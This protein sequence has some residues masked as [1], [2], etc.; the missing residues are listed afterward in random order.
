MEM[1][2]IV[3]IIILIA[4]FFKKI[5]IVPKVI[6]IFTAPISIRIYLKIAI[7]IITVILSID[8]IF[9]KFFSLTEILSTTNRGTSLTVLLFLY[10]NI[11]FN[12]I[13]TFYTFLC[14]MNI[15]FIIYFFVE[16]FNCFVEEK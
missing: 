2:I 5:L 7:I 9:F 4:D 11:N 8:T 14:E 15:K 6:I 13:T 1:I 3:F 12:R 16:N 10:Y